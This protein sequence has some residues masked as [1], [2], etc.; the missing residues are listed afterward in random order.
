MAF[1]W[2][3]CG[4][5]NWKPSLAISLPQV[6][7]RRTQHSAD[8]SEPVSS[9]SSGAGSVPPPSWYSVPNPSSSATQ[10][11]PVQP[12]ATGADRI[13][14]DRRQTVLRFEQM[15]RSEIQ[16]RV[17]QDAPIIKPAAA[18]RWSGR[19][20]AA[21]AALALALTG[22]GALAAAAATPNGI[23]GPSDRDGRLGPVQDGGGGQFGPGMPGGQNA[24]PG[25]Q[26]FGRGQQGAG[27][28]QGFGS[29]GSGQQGTTRGSR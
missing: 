24:N 29:S 5:S 6:G 21:I 18:A 28:G 2:T 14:P 20:T 1:L 27:P 10:P 15:P 8:V 17:P 9:P 25:Q 23:A 26:G 13:Q 12:D 11:I 4:L 7:H 19:R 22:A 3:F 16:D